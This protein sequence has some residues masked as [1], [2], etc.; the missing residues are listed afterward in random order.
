[1]R[2]LQGWSL[3]HLNKTRGTNY[4]RPRWVCQQEKWRWVGVLLGNGMFFAALGAKQPVDG[5]RGAAGG[6]MIVAYL[7]FAQ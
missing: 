6:F 3:K 5:I 4:V 7:H 2:R 1:M